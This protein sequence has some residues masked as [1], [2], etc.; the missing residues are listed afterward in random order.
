M[1]KIRE[2][3]QGAWLEWVASRPPVVRELC[4]RYP[5]DRLYLMKHTGQR[6]VLYSYNEDGTVTVQVLGKFNFVTF[7]RQVFGVDPTN[8]V[9]C[10]LPTPDELV[11][12]LVPG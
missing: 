1:A 6:V 8:L 12:A 7:E 10:D 5:P 4:E 2:M 3:D 11:G 9:E